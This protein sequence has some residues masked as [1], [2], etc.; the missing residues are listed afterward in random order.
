[1]TLPA[2]RGG[3][4]LRSAF[5]HRQAAYTS[6]I[7]A[8]SGIDKWDRSSAAE[9]DDALAFLRIQTGNLADT[10]GGQKERSAL[11]DDRQY[12]KL[13]DTSSIADQARIRSLSRDSAIVWIAAAP[14][15]WNNVHMSPQLFTT[16]IR[17]ILGIT[18]GQPNCGVCQHEYDAEEDD[19][20][21]HFAHST[22]LCAK[23]GAKMR[24]HHKI[25]D[26]LAALAKRGGLHV[27][28]EVS[29]DGT[30][31]RPGDI[32]IDQPNKS[33][34]IDVAITQ[35]QQAKYRQ[36]AAKETGYAAKRYEEEIKNDRFKSRVEEAG[37]Y[38]YTPFVMEVFGTT[39][40]SAQSVIRLIARAIHTS[41][42]IPFSHTVNM[43]RQQVSAALWRENAQAVIE[44]STP[45]VFRKRR[46]PSAA[47]P[48]PT[49]P[50]HPSPPQGAPPT[51]ARRTRHSPPPCTP[52]PA[53]DP[54]QQGE[55]ECDDAPSGSVPHAAGGDRQS[56]VDRREVPRQEENA[57]QAPEHNQANSSG[58]AGASSSA[59]GEQSTPRGGEG[60]KH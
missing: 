7:E 19:N 45:G 47:Q 23:G 42:A 11:I 21:E 41:S 36:Q 50:R 40:E 3:L 24:R 44:R 56:S 14:S 6:S 10:F 27:Q 15:R 1:M 9:F 4:G 43:V 20:W 55:A 16:A 35:P 38:V 13:L 51:E 54:K 52:H 2:R 33:L 37:E 46:Q 53:P 60:G 8:C 25:R 12:Q 31:K 17:G 48:S 57:N 34:V 26:T 5:T 59:G 32:V 18:P 39:T 22:G 49:P 30:S 58:A 29:I 28:T